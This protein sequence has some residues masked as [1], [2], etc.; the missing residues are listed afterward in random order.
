LEKAV[1]KKLLVTAL[2]CATVA[3]SLHIFHESRFSKKHLSLLIEEK[4]WEELSSR[5]I[6]TKNPDKTLSILESLATEYKESSFAQSYEGAKKILTVEN[7]GLSFSTIFPILLFY[8]TTLPDEIQKKVYFWPESRFGR[9]LQYDPETKFFFIHLGTKEIPPLGIGK[10][11]VVSK[12]ILYNAGNPKIV[13]RG[14][15]KSPSDH[16]AEAMHALNNL[17]GVIPSVT[18]MTHMDPT[19]GETIYTIVTPLY[20]KGSLQSLLEETSLTFEEKLAIAFDLS[21]GLAAIHQNGFVHRDL[22][23]RNYFV[24]IDKETR[25]IDAVV[26]DLEKA[27][28]IKKAKHVTVQ[29]NKSHTSPE[30]FFKEKMEG[31]MYQK[32]DAFAL[33]TVLYTLY[34]GE[35]APWKAHNSF[36]KRKLTIEE[37][38]ILIEYW[39]QYGRRQLELLL[40]KNDIDDR[41]KAF[42]R[43]IYD[44]TNIPSE[45]MSAKEAAVI[46]GSLLKEQV[47]SR[48]AAKQY[49]VMH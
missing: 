8:H 3:L 22:G 16:E 4:K 14:C 19:T 49:W 13:A 21:A 47:P 12:S 5:V 32:S 23:A 26:A 37:R 20:N 34:F 11:K 10:K 44:M 30:G 42:I 43:I 33:G 18:E 40:S 9:E 31:E 15:S 46:F 24:N 2:F 48:E 27:V 41:N 39:V 35:E 25:R 36:K 6:Y 17:Y 45:R 1:K 7:T 29:G 28:P 38:H